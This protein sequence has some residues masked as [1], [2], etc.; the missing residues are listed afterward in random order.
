MPAL[1]RGGGEVADALRQRGAQRGRVGDLPRLAQL[2]HQQQQPVGEREQRVQAVAAVAGRRQRRSRAVALIRA[3]AR[4]ARASRPAT[5]VRLDE[6]AAARRAARRVVDR[7]RRRWPRCRRRRVRTGEWPTARVR[8]REVAGHVQRQAAAAFELLPE[9]AL[10]VELEVVAAG[11]ERQL[12]RR[13]R[14]AR[15]VMPGSCR[16]TRSLMRSTGPSLDCAGKRWRTC[17]V[18]N[19]ER[20]G[21]HEAERCAA[22]GVGNHRGAH[23]V[24]AVDQLD[25][26]R[27]ALDHG[28]EQCAQVLDHG[29][30][31]ALQVVVLV[32]RV[33]G[34]HGARSGK[35]GQFACELEAGQV[36]RPRVHA[37]RAGELPQRGSV[38]LSAC[39]TRKSATSETPCPSWPMP[40]P[41]LAPAAG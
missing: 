37:R 19:C 36:E 34:R 11:V 22:V 40:R 3:A 5:R 6:G 13:H 31:T 39:S 16:L 12:A 4:S 29:R 7:R 41:A 18:G 9:F 23:A 38:R 17:S 26:H 32:Q 33:L 24:A 30:E 10:A 8:G 28:R 1:L 14:Q 20:Y 35:R 21:E 27:V 2:R 25:R 15:S